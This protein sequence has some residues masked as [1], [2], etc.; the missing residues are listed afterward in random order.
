MMGLIVDTDI[1]HV[2]L[3]WHVFRRE[4][5]MDG[6]RGSSPKYTDGQ[7]EHSAADSKIDGHR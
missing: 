6:Y 2:E 3:V 1:S 4:L 7:R 5:L